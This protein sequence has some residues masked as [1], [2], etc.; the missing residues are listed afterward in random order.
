ML[1]II[2]NIRARK[3]RPAHSRLKPGG[4]RMAAR[5]EG[6]ALSAM[7]GRTLGVLLLIFLFGAVRVA[8]PG[9]GFGEIHVVIKNHQFSPAE[10]KV[11]AD[12][13]IKLVVRNEDQAAEEFE[14]FSLNRE[15]LIRAGESVTIFLPPLRPG[16]YEFFGEFHQESARGI[17][18]AE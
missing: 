13:K 16:R 2:L 10:L 17:I 4:R 8:R 7:N 11:K 6:G 9:D 18:V 5:P 12:T 15:R 1:R 3:V 14:S